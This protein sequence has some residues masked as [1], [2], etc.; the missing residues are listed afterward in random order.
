MIG[1]AVRLPLIAS[2][3][4]GKPEHVVEVFQK[5]RASAAI[6]SSLLYSPRL[7]KNYSVAEIKAELQAA[8]IHVRPLVS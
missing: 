3:G 5:T 1:E 8:G 2:G 7:P 4:A 6:V